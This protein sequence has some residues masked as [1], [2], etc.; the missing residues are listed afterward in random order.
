M[1]AAFSASCAQAQAQTPPM[2]AV[3]DVIVT[4]TRRPDTISR[5][6]AA[7]TA[8]SPDVID[9]VGANNV[10][11]AVTTAPN[12]HASVANDVS[13]RGVGSNLYEASAGGT[14]VAI[15][16]DG[17]YTNDRSIL[18]RAA[19][20]IVRLEVLRGPQG[21]LYGRNATGG[22][23]NFV[24][25]APGDAFDAS[26]DFTYRSGGDAT[27]R[28]A[29]NLPVAP[30][31]AVRLAA[32]AEASDGFQHNPDS[33]QVDGDAADF[34]SG[35]VSMRWAPFDRLTWNV[36]LQA[37]RDRGFNG[38]AQYS[39]YLDRAGDAQPTHYP[40]DETPPGA[41]NSGGLAAGD[42]APSDFDDRNRADLGIFSV[43]SNLAYAFAN[44]FSLSYLAGYN[45]IDDHGV[46]NA[47]PFILRRNAIDAQ[48]S[49]HELNLNYEGARLH[50]VAGLYHFA[51]IT[52]GAN[53]ISV[54]TQNGAD[55]PQLSP[56]VDQMNQYGRGVNNTD[57]IFGQGTLSFTDDLRF[58]LGA[59]YTRDKIEIGAALQ[60]H[61]P[62]G[63]A[64]SPFQTAEDILYNGAT[65]ASYNFPNLAH[66]ADIPGVTAKFGRPSYLGTL[67][68]DLIPSVLA[69]ATIATGYRTGGV[70][71]FTPDVVYYQP[72]TNINYEAGMRARL[73]S[74]A[75]MLNLTI[76]RE[77]YRNMQIQVLDLPDTHTLNAAE[78]TIDGVEAEY[79]L[80]FSHADR[81]SGYLTWLDARFDSFPN[82]YSGFRNTSV[83][84]AGNHLAQTPEWS[85][86]VSYSHTFDLHALGD[87]TGTVQTYWQA[88]SFAWYTNNIEDQVPAFTRSDVI[89][90]Y[91]TE[92]A[93]VSLEAFVNNIEDHQNV[94]SVF[95]AL[96]LGRMQWAFYARGRM[97]GVR[98]GVDF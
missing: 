9:S 77:T 84:A 26:A 44:G 50:A 72:E 21:T 93:H 75:L 23:L 59:R 30:N 85:A 43:R 69:Y 73:L 13:I 76:F 29:L 31:L 96:G 80:A 56:T 16:V 67:E 87:V 32:F 70:S 58:T 12:L 42:N 47:I 34:L 37:S 2:A 15:H 53:V 6:P 14:P 54:W 98:L 28:G 24:T 64:S 25:A 1:L 8:V 49:S 36:T 7:I 90:R 63:L 4:A 45:H 83:D 27:V 55:F 74:N 94:N 97:A 18:T 35:R 92:D 89:V 38:I 68:Y 39:Y 51:E 22:V 20:D 10:I 33:G 61:C 95:P 62:F 88:D 57:A 3:E 52:G 82:A 91:Q 48:E 86:R 11:D 17:I 46:T 65:C 78:A 79:F 81:L 60:S 40:E 41:P 5:T 71:E 19:Y 66:I